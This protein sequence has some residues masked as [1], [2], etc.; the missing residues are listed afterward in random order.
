MRS[1]IAKLTSAAAVIAVAAL[2]IV[3]W[4][5][6]STPAYA[7]EQTVE[8]LQ[9]V[10]FLHI[11]GRDE[12]GQINDERWIEIG[13]DGYQVRYRQQNPLS[14]IENHPGSPSMVIEDGE[15]TAVYRQEKKAVI[16]YDRKERQYQW[17][18]QLGKAFENLLQEGKILEENSEYQG[19]PAHKVWWPFMSAECYVD[20]ETKLPMA[21]G[22]TELSYEE[23]PTGT[24]EITIPDGF[25]V[26]DKR[27]GAT[28]TTAPDWLIEEEEAGHSSGERFE[29]GTAALIRG[30]YAEA[31]KQLEQALGHDSW[32]TFWLGSAYYEL[33]QYDQAAKCFNEMLNMMLQAFGGDVLPYCNYA[34]GLAQAKGGNLEAA[35][36]NFQ[37][38][39]PSMIQTLRTPSAG[40]MFEYA[41]N[42]R[43]RYG[44]HKPSDQ[45]MVVKM[46]NR[47]RIITGQNF[48]YDP[49]L[50]NEQNEAAIAAWEQWFKTDGQIRFTPA[51]ELLPVPVAPDLKQ[52][53]VEDSPLAAW[54]KNLG[55]GRKSNQ[56]IAAKYSSEWL[57]QIENP[58]ILL[59]S[60][61]A[62]YDV[63]RYKEA[64]ALFEQ[65]EKR[66]GED[67]LRLA[68]ALVWQGQML[69]LLGTRD[70]AVST[71]QKVVNMGISK[72]TRIRHDQF[73][74]AYSPS[75][76]AAERMTTPFVRVENLWED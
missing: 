37:A 43:I 6:F 71:Y 64:L 19:R 22:D 30:D 44:Q 67:Q 31:A 21:I 36:A 25:A 50:T 58:G 33:G 26:V 63:G 52:A 23:P 76:Y 57:D 75:V 53:D 59:R 7:I 11:I 15:S 51:A 55:Y 27:P 69:D 29:D 46:V 56:E 74:L 3:F 16:I 35:T 48:G 17:V 1:P 10:R 41:D 5:R 49:A 65:M 66:A 62:L 8:A 38:C 20:P 18:G 2:S 72:E 9:N 32:A 39:L 73:G 70:L 60:G 34:L 68:M 14:V 42:A 4:G 61:M 28:P 13:E 40:K 12:A 45:E 47:L 24:W 54:M